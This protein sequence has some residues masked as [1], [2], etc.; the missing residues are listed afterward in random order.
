MFTVILLGFMGLACIS[1][2][3][4]GSMLIIQVIKTRKHYDALESVV[5]LAICTFVI[6]CSTYFL[7]L[8]WK[9]VELYF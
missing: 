9:A 4:G 7:L 1:G 6:S 2:L 8:L 5:V 3:F